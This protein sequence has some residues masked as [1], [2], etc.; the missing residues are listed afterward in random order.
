MNIVLSFFFLFLVQINLSKHCTHWKVNINTYTSIHLHKVNKHRE[1]TNFFT[2]TQGSKYKQYRTLKYKRCGTQYGTL[3][4]KQ[5]GTLKYK[6]YSTLKCNTNE[7]H[8]PDNEKNMQWCLYSLL[9]II[10]FFPPKCQ[11]HHTT[12]VRIFLDDPNILA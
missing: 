5:Y 12:C 7:N 11:I 8:T 4:Y 1:C 2:Y 10:H 9:Q 3:N 6:Q